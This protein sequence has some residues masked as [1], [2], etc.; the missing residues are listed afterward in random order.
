MHIP[1]LH[2]ETSHSNTSQDEL[3]HQSCSLAAQ[4]CMLYVC[5]ACLRLLYICGICLIVY[6]QPHLSRTQHYVI[7]VTVQ[8]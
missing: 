5:K 8:Q 4:I 2:S 1:R 3:R 6:M 7:H